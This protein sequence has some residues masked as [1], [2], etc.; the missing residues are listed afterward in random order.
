MWICKEV[1]VAYFKELYKY[2]T[3]R[4]KRTENI[5]LDSRS[6]SRIRK[7]DLPNTKKK[8]DPLKC[9]VRCLCDRW[10][11]QSEINIFLINLLGLQKHVT[12]LWELQS[13]SS[14]QFWQWSNCRIREQQQCAVFCALYSWIFKYAF[15]R[16]DY[17]GS[18]EIMIYQKW[19]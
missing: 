10:I 18:N 16:L 13:Q 7:G 8:W 11:C 9:D 2:L 4:R 19:N 12:V 15:N 6:R 1:F 5:S 3:A 14:I 17:N